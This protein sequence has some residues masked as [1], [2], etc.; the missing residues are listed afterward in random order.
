MNGRVPRDKRAED[1]ND[2]RAL[3]EIFPKSFNKRFFRGIP[4]PSGNR[5][6]NICV[7][8]ELFRF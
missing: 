3:S 8:H 6:Q 4:A 2:A 5:R 7:C 1:H